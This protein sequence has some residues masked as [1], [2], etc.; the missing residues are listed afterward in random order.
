MSAA[1]TPGFVPF[2][3]SA[4]AL[5][6]RA[7]PKK[8]PPR[9]FPIIRF[10]AI[11]PVLDGLWVI[12]GLLPAGGLTAVY[13]ASQSGKSFLLLD[14]LLHVAAGREWASRKV[15]QTRV[16]FIAAEGQLGFMNRVIAARAKLDLPDNTPFDLIVKV[17]NF[18]TSRED[19]NAL[20]AEIR[21][22]Y[23]DDIPGIIGIDTL[24]QVMCGGNE[25]SP[26]GMG[27]FLANCKAIA[28]ALGCTVIVT[29]HT[30]KDAERGE[31]GHSSLPANIDARWL[32]E[33]LGSTSRVTVKKQRDGQ[34][35]LQWY[36]RLNQE[37]IGWDE[38]NYEVTSCSVEIIA[39]PEPLKPQTETEAGAARQISNRG[40]RE[41]N[42]AFD[43]ALLDHG[44]MYCVGGD[45]TTRVKA[46]RVPAIKRYF[47]QRWATGEP[48]TRKQDKAA[49]SAFKRIV[50]NP[51]P[52]YR[53]A[54]VGDTEWI[55]KL[56]H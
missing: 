54:T 1:P 8:A 29:H 34:D 22:E 14:A 32:V 37:T 25:N 31:R 49:S 5:N 18:G 19:A 33:K 16:L 12:K 10:K 17:P 56:P 6:V 20:I 46:L 36:F 9:R 38:D 11:E 44:E 35:A 55:W 13:G 53:R 21:A 23:G 41:F 7:V 47:K 40:H 27:M 45:L 24:S 30:G 52:A 2:P 51:P 15:N 26:E 50:S 48:D 42:A 28:E 43:E 3:S 39:Q 4:S